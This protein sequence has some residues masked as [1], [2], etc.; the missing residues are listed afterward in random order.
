MEGDLIV[1]QVSPWP[2][3]Y[4]IYLLGVR[5]ISRLIR[6]CL[7]WRKVQSWAKDNTFLLTWLW[8]AHS[9]YSIGCTDTGWEGIRLSIVPQGKGEVARLWVYCERKRNGEY[10]GW[11]FLGC[12]WQC[13]D[14]HGCEK[15]SYCCVWCRHIHQQRLQHLCSSLF[16]YCEFKWCSCTL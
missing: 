16:I 4:E 12:E 1:L 10:A 7:C 8:L 13:Q 14:S 9:L 2:G 5:C 6:Q 15:L 11:M 3:C